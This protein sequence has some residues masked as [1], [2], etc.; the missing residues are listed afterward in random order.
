MLQT[1]VPEI[2]AQAA[3]T[4]SYIQHE[5]CRSTCRQCKKTSGSEM[6]DGNV[7]THTERHGALELQWTNRVDAAGSRIEWRIETDFQGWVSRYGPVF[8]D[9]VLCGSRTILDA[10]DEQA[11]LHQLRA[12]L[13]N[14]TLEA[15]GIDGANLRAA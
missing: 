4:P 7:H 11:L 2:T 8:N 9:G 15:T 1:L 5:S 12:R 6:I 3:Y 14:L 10:S 13:R